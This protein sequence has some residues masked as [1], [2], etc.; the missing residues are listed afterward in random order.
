MK[1]RQLIIYLGILVVLGG[2]YAYF[3][4][5]KVKEKQA[6]QEKASTVF[7]LDKA[8]INSLC[9]ERGER[10]SLK[11]EGNAWWIKEPIQEKADQGAV[12][13]FLI[14]LTNLKRERVLGSLA[15][16][17]VFEKTLTIAFT[18]GAK[19]YNL[20]IGAQTP[21][22]EFR[23]AKASTVQGVFL[24]QDYTVGGLDKDLFALR[25]KRLLTLNY[26]DIDR[27]EMIRKGFRLE[28]VKDA[29][30]TWQMSG[31][32][33]RIKTVKVDSLLREFCWIEAKLFAEGMQVNRPPDVE[34]ML[35]AKGL[36]QNVK[37]WE[38]G[39]AL[40]AKSDIRPHVVEID[41]TVLDQLPTDVKAIEDRSIVDLQEGSVKKVTLGEKTFER[42]DAEWFAG[43]EKLKAG[44]KI[45]SLLGALSRLEYEE[46][47]A[48]LPKDAQLEN[49]VAI[50][51]DEA[52]TVFDIALYAPSSVA[53]NGKV[54]R[55][56]QGGYRMI[57]DSIGILA[58]RRGQ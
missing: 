8:K 54:F 38:V 23:Y 34:I 2:S 15:D 33:V 6:Q 57:K 28:L 49:R 17:S 25:D 9:V 43:E 46:T 11:K 53:V 50:F 20:T 39:K 29:Q 18:S 22:K 35:K 48:A 40:F 42:R 1:I 45:D 24:V 55:V 19:G 26:S 4:V 3:E 36:T 44:W 7:S 56:R 12:D 58:E 52:K 5:Y 47:L 13:T 51:Y 32:N 16:L 21:T 10:I 14:A 31:R 41:K 27:V 37:L 30:G